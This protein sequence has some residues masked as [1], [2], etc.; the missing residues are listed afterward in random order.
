[1]E[2]EKSVQQK[3]R[4]LNEAEMATKIALEEQNREL[5][6]L[7]SENARLEADAKAYGISAVMGALAKTDPKTLQALASV[8]MNPGQLV[9]TAFRELAENADK[10][11]QLNISPD[12]LRELMSRGDES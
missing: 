3:M 9:A 10:I 6:S 4:E 11:G 5:V 7:S 1:M 8:G 2:A 12:L